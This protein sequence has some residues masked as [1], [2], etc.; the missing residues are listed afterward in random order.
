MT[1]PNLSARAYDRILRVS[2][3]VVDLTDPDCNTPE[4]VSYAIGYRTIERSGYDFL[5]DDR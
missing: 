5:G 1:E 2:R 4:H 3:P